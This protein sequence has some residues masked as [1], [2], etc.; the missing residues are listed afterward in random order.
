[1]L[2][3][4][5]P[6]GLVALL[7]VAQATVTTPV[8]AP[9]LDA[10][11]TQDSVDVLVLLSAPPDEVTPS[12]DAAQVQ[13]YRVMPGLP[14][15]AAHVTRAGLD[16]LAAHPQV[17]GVQLSRR[18]RALTAESAV[19]VQADVVRDTWGV[20]GKDVVVAAL[21]TGVD[22]THPDL[23]GGLAGQKCFVT[24]GCPPSNSNVGELAPEGSGHGT[25]VAGIITGDG[26]V[27]PKGLAPG[28]RVLMVRVFDDTSYGDEAD[29]A[30]AMDWLATNAA[31]LKLRVV[32]MSIGTDNRYP[33]TCDADWPV[34]AVAA[35][36]L[37][38]AGV[39][40]FASSGNEA[41]ANAMA[42]PACLPGVV[43]VGSTYDAALGRQPSSG[44]YS[45]GCFDAVTD[46]GAVMCLSN[47]S[48]ELDLLAPG[49]LT[50]AAAPGGGV[51]EKRGTS[52]AAPHASAVAALMLEVDPA[53]TPAD[54]ARILKATGRPTVDP[55]APGRTTPF[56]DARAAVEATWASFCTRHEDGARCR[57]S[58]GTC[59]GGECSGVCA[60]SLCVDGPVVL[61]RATTAEGQATVV[62]YCSCSGVEGGGALAAVAL[63]L[64]RRR[65][66]RSPR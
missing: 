37:L 52:Q 23:D 45:S 15:F 54:I 43:A 62:V 65:S 10:L 47:T 1:M 11:R 33:G 8:R 42:A 64:A 2:R 50:R 36:H 35:Q 56:L 46:A 21:D 12:F 29:W 13:V 34:M 9:V 5:T 27:A 48:D 20:T 61:P 63:W 55:K 32:N 16:A 14:A 57:S 51:A 41:E 53:L 40:M 28:A 19:A 22:A 17:V 7:V 39:V 24:G 58:F 30:V 31:S 25:H 59:D 66:R 44:T 6:F 18:L 26:V 49:A 38:D 4:V 60:A 3:G